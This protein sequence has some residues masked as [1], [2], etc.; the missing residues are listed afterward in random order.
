MATVN[1]SDTEE[2]E[3]NYLYKNN[4]GSNCI[5]V[6]CFMSYEKETTASKIHVLCEKFS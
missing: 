2:V 1:A 5:V 3:E 6:N 4:C